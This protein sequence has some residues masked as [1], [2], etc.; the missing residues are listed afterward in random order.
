M[1]NNNETIELLFEAEGAGVNSP[2][3]DDLFSKALEE[4]QEC[5]DRVDRI[6]GAGSG[7]RTC[8]SVAEIESRVLVAQEQAS[9][10]VRVHQG[11]G[12]TK[13]HPLY[14]PLEE[15]EEIPISR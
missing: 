9:Q 13:V 6:S 15:E 8:S 7:V 14:Y 5:R 10:K 1:V 11:V 3:M 4:F 2:S 12:S